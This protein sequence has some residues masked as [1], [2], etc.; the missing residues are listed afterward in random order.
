MVDMYLSLLREPGDR[1]IPADSTIMARDG[2]FQIIHFVEYHSGIA[3]RHEICPAGF[4]PPCFWFGGA[5]KYRSNYYGS[6]STSELVYTIK[7]RNTITVASSSETI[8]HL[9]GL[10]VSVIEHTI[11]R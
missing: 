11:Q 5:P 8:H 1:S 9:T 6:R 10:E 4:V 2:W 7:H 3:R